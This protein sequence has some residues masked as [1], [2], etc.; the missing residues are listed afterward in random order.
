MCWYES[1]N[2]G[3]VSCLGKS[4]HSPK[5]VAFL[6]N[7]WTPTL[8]AGHAR[9]SDPLI[10]IHILN[11]RDWSPFHLELVQPIVIMVQVAVKWF[12]G[13]IW[14][15][16]CTSISGWGQYLRIG[17]VVTFD[18]WFDSNCILISQ[19]WVCSCTF[20]WGWGQYLYF[21]IMFGF[22]VL[23]RPQNLYL[24]FRF[25]IALLCQVQVGF[26][27]WTSDLDL[28]LGLI[29]NFISFLCFRVPVL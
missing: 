11:V 3:T 28:F 27:T 21:Y 1:L 17:S 9:L 2:T 22:V 26:C 13:C 18:L 29:N 19:V 15:C 4:I 6:Y 24:R 20:I 10:F 7:L 12:Y 25:M 5:P 23:L 8:T 14:A 16:C